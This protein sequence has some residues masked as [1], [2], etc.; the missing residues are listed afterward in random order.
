MP[1]EETAT[2]T[3]DWLARENDAEVKR[4]LHHTVAAQTHDAQTVADPAIIEQAVRDLAVQPAALTRQSL[5]K[6]LGAAVKTTP[7]AKTALLRQ[8]KHEAE[9]DEGL[10]ELIATFIDGAELAAALRG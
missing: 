9:A 1:P 3:A 6:I 5:I 2:I 8:A 4:V 7:A 10:L